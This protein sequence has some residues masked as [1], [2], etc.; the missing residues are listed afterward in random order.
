MSLSSSLWVLPR[1]D[2]FQHLLGLLSPGPPE[3][4]WGLLVLELPPLCQACS[5]VEGGG[6]SLI[7]R[8]E[9]PAGFQPK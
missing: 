1:P 7:L 3:S 5:L 4:V 9:V 8:L 2:C 6:W